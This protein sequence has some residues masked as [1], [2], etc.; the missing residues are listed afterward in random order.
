MSV[1]SK[2]ELAQVALASLIPGAVTVVGYAVFFYDKQGILDWWKVC[3]SRLRFFRSVLNQIQVASSA[4][5]IWLS[6][7]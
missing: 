6:V 2:D 1:V 5:Q 4:R 7:K 3:I